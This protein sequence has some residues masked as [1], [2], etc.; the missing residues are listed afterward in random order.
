M[1]LEKSAQCC[2]H[3]HL[4]NHNSNDEVLLVI[5]PD[6]HHHSPCCR[7]HYTTSQ[8]FKCHQFPI[9]LNWA[10]SLLE[11]IMNRS[12]TSQLLTLKTLWISANIAFTAFLTVQLAYVLEG[13]VTPETRVAELGSLSSGAKMAMKIFV[14]HVFTIFASNASFLCVIANLQN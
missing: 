4:C 11:A 13:Y 14:K 5:N 9:N 3:R 12:W 8:F 10:N 7:L 1:T 2:H 6:N